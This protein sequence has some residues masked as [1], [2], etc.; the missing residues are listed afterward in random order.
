MSDWFRK[1]WHS[2]N[3]PQP[4]ACQ[5]FPS[6][7]IQASGEVRRLD[8]LTNGPKALRLVQMFSDLV[9]TFRRRPPSVWRGS[10]D[11]RGNCTSFQDPSEEKIV[12]PLGWRLS[13]RDLEKVEHARL[14]ICRENRL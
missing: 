11:R 9:D 13:R 8:W 12:P 5:L 4:A 3:T 14:A 6:A 2:T 10:A 1:P 7:E